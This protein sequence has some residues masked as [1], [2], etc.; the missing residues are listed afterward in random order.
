MLVELLEGTT[1]LY[2]GLVFVFFMLSVVA[3]NIVGG[4][5][6]PSGGY[7][8]F[9]S[10]LVVV[11]GT[12][13]KALLGQPAQT[14]LAQPLLV[15]STYVATMG[16]MA[17]TGFLSSRIATTTDGV[18]G[19][20][21]VSERDFS[22]SALGCLVVHV[23]I[24]TAATTLPGGGGQVIH[25]LI[26]VNPF[27]LL[28]AV[29]GTIAAVQRSHGRR[30]TNALTICTL[31]YMLVNGLLSF[32]KQGML[33]PLVCWVLGTAWARF[34][35]RGIH[36]AGLF[37]YAVCTFEVFSP[38]SASRDDLQIG[39]TAERW[40]LIEHYLT[41]LGELHERAATWEVDEHGIGTKLLYYG[42]PQGLWDRLSML[43]NDA[44]LISFSDQGNY[45]GYYAV[46]YYFR[47]LIPHV[48]DPHRAEDK[49]VGGNAYAHEM[50]G[51]ADAD[52]ST[53]ISFSPTAE[54]YHI[55][56]WR[57]VL[58][59]QPAIF[60]LLFLMADSVSGDIRKHPWGLFLTLSFAHVAPEA[61]LG[62]TISEL[63]YG[64]VSVSLAVFFCGYVTPVLGLLLRGRP[65]FRQSSLTA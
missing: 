38:I 16:G 9:Y 10:L 5:S 51:L 7:I 59:L 1:P 49:T 25:S 47:A 44:L 24:M 46:L 21:N 31:S 26:L 60:L 15:M 55:D 11:V 65:S 8:G 23:V 41:H 14:Y 2:S 42:K 35:L 18:A 13:Y 50:G 30:S 63:T 4:F 64:C 22:S 52:T 12:V 62:G 28:S 33:L 3:F 54:A 43:P 48:L 17:L 53:G 19:L 29:L 36:I 37:L 6:R 58:I 34:P 40:T 57:G 20:M 39:S 27:F 56:G 45:R 61:L 32:S